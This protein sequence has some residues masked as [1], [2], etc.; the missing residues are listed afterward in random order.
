MGIFVKFEIG[1][2]P[3]IRGNLTFC[4]QIPLGWKRTHTLPFLFLTPQRHLQPVSPVFRIGMIICG[5]VGNLNPALIKAVYILV[6]E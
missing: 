2:I 6:S 5:S 1:G 4:V 3:N